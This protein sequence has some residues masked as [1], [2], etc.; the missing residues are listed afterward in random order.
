MK[1]S[2]GAPVY[3]REWVLDRWFAS[4]LDQ[5]LSLKNTSIIFAYTEGNDN[6][7][8][9]IHKYGQK[10]SDCVVLECNDLPAF[11]DRNPKRYET[12]AILR[13]R[14]ID[15]LREL[16]PDYYVSWDTDILLPPGTVKGLIKDNKDVVGPYV[17]LVPP[18]DIPNCATRKGSDFR[19]IKPY[20]KFYPK[21]ELFEVDA[22]FA[23]SAMKN[24]VFNTCYYKSHPGGEDY[25]WAENLR[26]AGFHSWMDSRY[27]G[28]HFY[29]RD[30]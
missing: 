11:V 17:D 5:E 9:I 28:K 19:R 30:N 10:F 26:D 15:K 29:R 4:I 7:L 14:I 18:Q 25:G 20:T 12:L 2:I 23:V 27:I 13:N 16:Q 8:D 21:G 3:Q 24:K 1:I 22:V 6:T